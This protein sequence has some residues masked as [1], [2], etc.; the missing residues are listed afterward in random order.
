MQRILL[1]LAL[2]AATLPAARATDARCTVWQRE[3]AFA[4]AVQ[5]HD[6]QAI[7]LHVATGAV[8]DAN[9]AR[10]IRGRAAI[11]GAW[12]PIVAGKGMRLRWYPDQVVLADGVADTAYSSGPYLMEQNGPDGR[13]RRQLGRF[14]SVWHRDGDGVW[15]V[16]FD[17]GERG[18]EAQDADVAAFEAG[19]RTECPVA[20]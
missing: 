20:G 17:G 16:L 9:G 14:A 12:A 11:A 6:P 18:R 7:E 8:F 4:R 5:A 3:L 1:T 19:H 15:R 10:P 2:G 13:P